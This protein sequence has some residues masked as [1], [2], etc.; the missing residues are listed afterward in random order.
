LLLVLA[1]VLSPFARGETLEQYDV[2]VIVFRNLSG[3]SD[4]EQW[5][6]RDPVT[7]DALPR[8]VQ[9]ISP[10]D[11]PVPASRLERIA[12]SLNRS[13]AYRV[14]EHRA[15]RQTARDRAQAQP[16]R[17][18]AAGGTLDGT[19]TL[20]RERYLH[21]DVDLFLDSTYAL[22]ERRRMRSG[23]LHYFDHPAFGVLVEVR[24]YE[25]PAPEPADASTGTAPVAGGDGAGLEMPVP[26]S[27]HRVR[28]AP[29]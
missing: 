9:G 1:L 8:S 4:G 16:V 19:I 26:V 22:D 2:E 29:Y 10:A 18:Q 21:L 12:D 3:Q 7:G 17:I 14:L 6:L 15:W 20:A 11:L 13:A 25:A 27:D 24:P 5:P 23:E 28:Q